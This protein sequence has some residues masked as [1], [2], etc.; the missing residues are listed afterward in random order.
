MSTYQKG[1]L[2]R[3]SQGGLKGL[4][5][6]ARSSFKGT[7]M[8]RT[9]KNTAKKKFQQ[10]LQTI[11]NDGRRM[12]PEVKVLDTPTVAQSFSTTYDLHYVNLVRE[13]TG[14]W[15]R[16]GRK[17][18]MKSLYLTGFVSRTMNNAAALLEDYGRIIVVYDRQSNGAVFNLNDVLLNTDQAG[19]TTTDGF[20]QINMNNRER[21][22]ILMDKRIVLP[23]VGIAGITAPL[24]N[25]AMQVNINEDG[26]D[27][28]FKITRFIKLQD[29]ETHFLSN[30][31]PITVADITTGG[32]AIFIFS[33]RA[34]PGNEGYHI[35]WTSR[36][37][38]YDT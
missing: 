32:L 36:L 23:Q 25:T 29:L 27:S 19:T 9:N 38:F 28:G 14:F 26:N 2:K 33:A 16:V 17:I 1:F 21:F 24:T 8:A 15:N 37:K 11:P 31:V 34:A 6:G 18:C 13:G 3:R 35:Q 30:S 4:G 10:I 20:A 22:I 7:S 12:R 5:T